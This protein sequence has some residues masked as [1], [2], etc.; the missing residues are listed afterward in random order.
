MTFHDLDEESIHFLI[1]GI[2]NVISINVSD[3]EKL[4]FKFLVRLRNYYSVFKKKVL[5]FVIIFIIYQ[6]L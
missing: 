3:L 2:V 1:N 5:L 6:H 4:R